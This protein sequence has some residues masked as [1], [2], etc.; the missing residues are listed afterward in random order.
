M[1]I[2]VDFGLFELLGLLALAGVARDPVARRRLRRALRHAR[3]KL[4]RCWR[5]MAG[6]AAGMVVSWGAVVW[7]GPHAGR[8]VRIV[9]WG[10]AVAFTA[11]AALHA[12]VALYRVL[13]R[14]EGRISA[15]VGGCGCTGRARP[16][17]SES[18]E[19]PWSRP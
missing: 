14:L 7:I 15:V 19:R 5:C 8:I 2:F 4:G 16:R 3:T 17:A 12:V 18:S 10:A 1:E 6:A 13:D 11:L 9:I